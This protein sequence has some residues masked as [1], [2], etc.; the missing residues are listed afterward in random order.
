MLE[1]SVVILL[2]IPHKSD[3]PSRLPNRVWPAGH[4]GV[5]VMHGQP[6]TNIITARTECAAE[7]KK[8]F[9]NIRQEV[10]NDPLMLIGQRLVTKTSRWEAASREEQ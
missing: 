7:W 2:G 4:K 10:Q 6:A 5:P 8:L 3:V 9:Q 1:G